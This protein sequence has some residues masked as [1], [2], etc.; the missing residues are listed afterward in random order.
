MLV[1]V[2]EDGVLNFT[3]M[4]R[5]LSYILWIYDDI[6]HTYDSVLGN[7]LSMFPS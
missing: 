5:R 7:L 6:V 2:S 4:D 3:Y 1:S